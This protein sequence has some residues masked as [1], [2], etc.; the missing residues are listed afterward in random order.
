MIG[1]LVGNFQIIAQLGKGGM[2]DVW[3][4]EHA[5]MK[6]RVAIKMLHSATTVDK[7][8]VQRFFN[9]AVAV[10]KIH[11]AGIVKIFDSGFHPNGRAYLV[12]EL[13]EGESL[14]KRIQRV[15]RLPIG[16]VADIGRQIASVLDATHTAGITHRD[17][18]PD[19]IFMVPDDELASRERV[20][21]LDFGIAKLASAAMTALDVSSI[22]T[23]N[24][25][26]PEQWHSLA[27]VDWRTDAYSLGCVAF[28]M[29]TGR[30]PFVASSLGEACQMHLMDPPVAPSS[31]VPGLPKAFDDL[32]LRLLEKEAAPRPT[33]RETMATLAE[34][35]HDQPRQ[36]A[37]PFAAIPPTTIPPP[38][39]PPTNRSTAF[40]YATHDPPRGGAAATAAS[41]G[42]PEMPEPAGG[43]PEPPPPL[44]RTPDPAMTMPV[45]ARGRSRAGI[46]MALGV[47]LIAGGVAAAVMYTNTG[48]ADA[49]PD[50]ARSAIVTAPPSPP[51]PAPVVDAAA[52]APPPPA[53]ID[54]AAPVVDAPEVATASDAAARPLPTPTP[55]PPTPPPPVI[56]EKLT[57]K[58]I[59]SA[60]AK[61]RSKVL[62]CQSKAPT[63]GPIQIAL[64]IAPDGKVSKATSD[65]PDPVQ[66]SCVE[67]AIAA[68]RFPK[69]QRGG[70]T[71]ATFQ[72]RAPERP[73]NPY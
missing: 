63:E 4:G 68:A 67:R 41:Y 11:H 71:S 42:P 27:Q 55:T 47:L 30:V 26:S 73:P 33:M 51:P 25:M 54:A 17:L 60:I 13:L 12:M 36:M 21:V 40:G 19:N 1:Q 7:H 39:I 56:A 53:A 64:T 35:A 57:S 38:K 49:T 29:A 52:P 65:G 61:V 31:L 20:K 14:T 23:P 22:G 50:A 10:S 8:Q 37:A 62:A 9:E 44:P 43:A 18:K 59:E 15:G 48:S 69:S 45:H 58:Q 72:F 6:T 3:L 28:E 24:Y 34:L 2:G 66:N 16:Q 5:A 46:L 32:V 70:T